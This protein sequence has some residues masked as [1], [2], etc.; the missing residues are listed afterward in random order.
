MFGLCLDCCLSS[1]VA[2]IT[3]IVRT[4]FGE[5]QSVVRDYARLS[6]AVLQGCL[7]Y[8][9]DVAVSDTKRWKRELSTAHTHK[10]C[11]WRETIIEYRGITC[12]SSTRGDLC[13]FGLL[14]GLLCRLYN[15]YSSHI[16]RVG[17]NQSVV[18]DYAKLP[19]AALQGCLVYV[20]DAVFAWGTKRSDR[21]PNPNPRGQAVPK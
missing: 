20:C 7:V 12:Y 17:E 11:W 1:C 21:K 6:A 3:H 5:N 13:M 16:V 8:V 10:H 14:F 15:A 2:F 9:Y 18:R 19:A 4:L